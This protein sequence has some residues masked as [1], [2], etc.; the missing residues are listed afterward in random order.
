MEL[1]C[2]NRKDYDKI[3]INEKYIYNSSWFH[4]LNKEKVEKIKRLLFKTKKYKLAIIGGIINKEMKFP[5][6]APFSI[7]EKLDK[8]ISI[9]N[10]DEMLKLL[11]DYCINNNIS[12]IS[13]K[14]PPF[15]YDETFC[16]KISN[17]FIRAGY[18]VDKYDLNYQFYLKNID[19]LNKNMKR[20]AIKN[21]NISKKFNYYLIHCDN[22]NLKKEAYNIIAENRKNKGYPLRMTWNQVSETINNLDHDIFILKLNNVSIASAIIFRV[23]IDVYQVIYWGDI[24]GY[25]EKRPMNYLSYYLCLYYLEKGIKVLDI[26]PSTE[27]GIPNFGLCSFKESIGCE[28]SGKITYLKKFR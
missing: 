5:Y 3:V 24:E 2:V 9:E 18:I 17:S 19:C 13:F 12:K 20:N 10:I 16:N 25:T 1:I 22:I 23:T 26:G 7:F 6:S 27:N 14:L 4:E 8:N 28:V 11:E 21:L 15:F